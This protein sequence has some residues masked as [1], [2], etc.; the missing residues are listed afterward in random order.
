MSRFTEEEFER[1]FNELHLD[2]TQ[3]KHF[4]E[5]I[6]TLQPEHVP[7]FIQTKKNKYGEEQVN[8]TLTEIIYS[9][10]IEEIMKLISYINRPD[11]TSNNILQLMAQ[12]EDYRD[13]P[14][15]HL[16]TFQ[17]PIL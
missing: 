12:Q 4:L 7:E 17:T 13:I 1:A 16:F 11:T 14:I 15:L 8:E 2:G 5:T 3:Y 10:N 6:L 9:N